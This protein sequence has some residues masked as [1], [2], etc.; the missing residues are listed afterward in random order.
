L[1]VAAVDSDL[2]KRFR[3]AGWATA[4][5]LYAVMVVAPVS[6]ANGRAVAV[7]AFGESVWGLPAHLFVP[8]LFAAIFAPLVYVAA[9]FMPLIASSLF[10]S[11]ERRRARIAVVLGGI[12]FALLMTAWIAY[13][14]F[15][16]I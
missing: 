4:L 7:K 9:Q 1:Q 12:Y 8:L 3:N 10:T 11:Q 2:K 6:D 13:T 14:S 16:G 5:V 15:L